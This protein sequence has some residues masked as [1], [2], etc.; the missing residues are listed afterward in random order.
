MVSQDIKFKHLFK[1]P[2]KNGLSKS[3]QVMGKGKKIIMM[4]EIFANRRIR[5]ISANRVP[6]SNK[7]IQSHSLEKGDLLFARTSLKFDGAGK[8]VIFNGDQET[9][10]FESNLIRCRLDQKKAN[11]HFYYYFFDSYV[12]RKKI[13]SILMETAATSMRSSDLG[14]LGVPYFDISFQNNVAKLLSTIEDK[15]E[16]NQKTTQTLEEVANTIFKSWFVDFDPVRAKAEGRST[17]LPPEISDL[18]PDDLVDSEIG[19]IPKGWEIVTFDH[20]IEFK[21]GYA[22]KSK[23]L[24]SDKKTNFAVFKM[25]HIRVGGGFNDTYKTDYFLPN[26]TPKLKDYCLKTGDILM[27]MTDMKSNVRLLGH[28]ALFFD[29]TTDFLVNQRVGLIRQ[30]EEISNYPYI[31][32]LTNSDRFLFDIRKNANSG[33]QVNLSTSGIKN[34]KTISPS[35]EIM[36]EFDTLATPIFERIFCFQRE[37]KVLSELR[38]TLLPKLISG[39]LR[40]PDAEKFLEEAGI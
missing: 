27:C 39:E 13:E 15:I 5:D 31:Y 25:G 38:D 11:S 8:C 24:S 28:T 6:L 9:V 1:I 22:F 19:E 40:I 32:C 30:K 18:F 36:K 20:L 10:V 29:Q 34:T 33:V 14:D 23:E 21:N 3:S 4:S 35:R 16:Q 37:S 7:E 2:T 12:G 26:V 17:G